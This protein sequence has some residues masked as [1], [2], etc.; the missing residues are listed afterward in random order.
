MRKQLKLSG[1]DYNG[2]KAIW[3]ENLTKYVRTMDA[4]VKRQKNRKNEE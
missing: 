4:Y 1:S 3:E 2:L